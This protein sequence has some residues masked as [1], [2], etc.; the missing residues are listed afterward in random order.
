M[1]GFVERLNWSAIWRASLSAACFA[2][3][4][5]LL[6]QWLISTGRL[7]SGD[8]ENLLLFLAIMFCGVLAG[9]G[10]AKLDRDWP[11]QNGAAAGAGA[12]LIVQL[13]GSILRLARG[14]SLSNPLGWVLL[15]MTMA[16]LGMFGAAVEKKS[17]ALR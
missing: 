10:A 2:L 13:G 3:P 9:F 14:E 5:G 8:A 12:Y 16:T 6:Q 1:G 4:L 17:R 7:A 11:I 15:A